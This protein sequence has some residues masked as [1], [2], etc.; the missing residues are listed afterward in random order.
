MADASSLLGP[1]LRAADPPQKEPRG[2]AS[3]DLV[4]ENKKEASCR[5]IT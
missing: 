1:C 5:G 3:T 4:S 2:K